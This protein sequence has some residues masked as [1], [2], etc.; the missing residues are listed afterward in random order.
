MQSQ[1][2]PLEKFGFYS[3]ERLM[4]Q[5][6]WIP[7]DTWLL[8]TVIAT[9]ALPRLIWI[10]AA[11]FMLDEAYL[12]LLALDNIANRQLPLLGMPSS[13]GFPNAPASVWLVMLLY[14]L[15]GSPLLVTALIA[16]L[17]VGG[18]G[19]L[20]LLGRRLL[21]REAAFIG[22]LLYALNPWAVVYSRKIWAQNM[23]TP[24]ILLA[25]VL[26]VWGFLDGRRW[27]QVLSLPVLLFGVQM[28]YAA[29]ALLPVYGWFL[30]QGQVKWRALLLSFALS[31]A[32]M[33]P[34]AIGL[35]GHLTEVGGTPAGLSR[36]L[37][38]TSDPLRYHLWLATGTGIAGYFAPGQESDALGVFFALQWVWGALMVAFVLVGGLALRRDLRLMSLIMLWIIVPMAAFIPTWTN[39]YTHY[40]IPTIPALSLLAGAG[41]MWV[42]QRRM[43]P[44][45]YA[46]LGGVGLLWVMQ[47]AVL[48]NYG[49][50]TYVVG[51]YGTPLYA[52]NTVAQA[53]KGQEGVMLFS[54]RYHD[55]TTEEPTYWGVLL[56]HD[57]CLRV[58]DEKQFTVIPAQ[59][60]QITS[61]RVQNSSPH[62]EPSSETLHFPLRD[63]EGEYIIYQTRAPTS[64]DVFPIG[65]VE[66]ANDVKLVGM[67]ITEAQLTLKWDL[68]P[69]SP[70]QN[71]QY[72]IHFFNAAGEKIGQ[73]DADF[74]PGRWW[75]QG[76]R[77][78]THVPATIPDET[79]SV[80]IGLYQL[81]GTDG[82]RNVDPVITNSNQ[83]ALNLFRPVPPPP[84]S[85]G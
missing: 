31:I 7:R 75:C 12:S 20:Y 25:F 36:N 78:F 13:T 37:S 14:A 43:V 30:V 3:T 55:F 44:V 8:L 72:F 16:L 40:F 33:T 70:G 39:A 79:A 28:H 63:G 81:V 67:D 62:V 46:L 84:D 61:F 82:F 68:P 56:Y 32:L 50:R 22:A 15:A 4:K 18:V 2:M 27:A 59:A 51:G 53:L 76:D 23:H 54:D 11:E 69:R 26:A 66:Y 10:D 77:L 24:F 83:I 34:T 73:R 17:N 35:W 74:M 47:W 21:W 38:V 49:T 19:L 60:A 42:S 64:P 41:A 48:L 45:V 65:P 71:L 6:K 57:D 9:A 29:W 1:S 52:Y 58:I 85:P 80:R 5:L